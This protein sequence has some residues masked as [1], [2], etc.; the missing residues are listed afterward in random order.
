MAAS[1]QPSAEEALRVALIARGDDA[2]EIDD[3]IHAIRS[4][5]NRYRERTCV[6]GAF[7]RALLAPSRSQPFVPVGP[8]ILSQSQGQQAAVNVDVSSLTEHQH[9]WPLGPPV[10]QDAPTS[11]AFSKVCV[12]H[13]LSRFRVG[14][15]EEKA[16]CLIYAHLM[17]ESK[18]SP[19]CKEIPAEYAEGA[20][21][22]RGPFFTVRNFDLEPPLKGSHKEILIVG[23][24]QLSKTP[25]AGASG[26][27]GFFVDGCVPIFGVR[28]KGGAETGSRDM[29]GGIEKLNK[30]IKEIFEHEVGAGNIGLPLEDYRKFILHPRRTSF[31]EQIEFDPNSLTLARPQALIICMNP[32]QVKNLIGVRAASEGLLEIM[33]G[34]T[35]HPYPPK[36]HDPYAPF[37]DGANRPVAR[38]WFILDEDDLNRSNNGSAT[39]RL[40]FD[41][42]PDVLRRLEKGLGALVQAGA[43]ASAAAAGSSQDPV[44]IETDDEPLLD[45][46]E[47]VP[48]ADGRTETRSG[49]VDEDRMRNE[50]R[51]QMDATG[52]RSAVRGVVALTATPSACGH[53]LSETASRVQHD[54]HCMAHPSNYVGYSFT[55]AEYAERT[56]LHEPVP[57]RKQIIAIKKA[58]IYEAVLKKHDWW[59]NELN[60]PMPP[61]KR[62]ADGA[63]TVKKADLDDIE[64]G[65]DKSSREI[66]EIVDR[67]QR[68]SSRRGDKVLESDGVGIALMLASMSTVPGEQERRALIISN[69]TK[70]DQQK[71]QLARHILE[72]DLMYEDGSKLPERCVCDLFVIILDHKNLRIMWRG[73]SG[74]GVSDDVYIAPDHDSLT[75]LTAIRDASPELN[76]GCRSADRRSHDEPHVEDL[77]EGRVKMFRS[78]FININHAY[79]ALLLYAHR[80]R[81][82]GRPFKLKSI[83]LAGDLGGRGINYKPHGFRGDTHDTWIIPPHHGYLTDMFFMFDAVVNRQ[84]TTHGE[85]I[86]QAIGRLCTLVDDEML[87]R[88]A[89]TPPRLFT[90][91]SCYSIIRTFALGVQQWVQVMSTK[92][93][94]ESIKDALVRSIRTE[95]ER[96]RELWMI[97]VVP[98]T[99]PRWAKKE[100]WVRTSRLMR[101]DKMVGE[102]VRAAPSM[103]AP[104]ISGGGGHG[105]QHN[106]DNDRQ[107]R[108]RSAMSKA[109]ADIAAGGDDE[110]DEEE[111]EPQPRVSRRRLARPANREQ[112][113]EKFRACYSSHPDHAHTA[114]GKPMPRF[115]DMI[116]TKW[117]AD[118]VAYYPARVIDIEWVSGRF[119]YDIAFTTQDDYSPVPPDAQKHADVRPLSLTMMPDWSY[120]DPTPSS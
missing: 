82:S 5:P 80:R 6:R 26:W 81:Q 2:T 9:Y 76:N 24:T 36:C 74:S 115:N 14:S 12:D 43:A 92:Q 8:S 11:H 25:E 30:R 66:A 69:Y 33:K 119:E 73:A 95:P 109:E 83:A 52:V 21:Q 85:Y 23:S 54:I 63:I 68:E 87:A 53:D 103:P 57:D 46:E 13:T 104:P 113:N 38:V 90:S 51:N 88:M 70:N 77:Y 32:N 35:R 67:T 28:N 112:M 56:I 99:D 37:D 42:P 44:T 93:H 114:C 89:T 61:F 102:S 31:G 50:F 117:D 98:H 41:A 111:E 29:A 10:K 39:E 118:N 15:E 18:P 48:A 79:T 40:Q 84:I 49:E 100:L 19:P 107:K 20:A 59:D 86:L 105:I 110:D 71:M 96:F 1:T 55:K 27:A 72:G 34:N 3:T 116:Y 45:E 108:I 47:D 91:Y 97:Y 58:P 94:N 60:E 62:R 65:G 75:V 7:A 106:P 64:E 17:Y 120:D 101:A 16:V 22:M 4:D 78:R